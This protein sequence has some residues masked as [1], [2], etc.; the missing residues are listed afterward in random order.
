MPILN[1]TAD[2]GRRADPAQAPRI[3][4]ESEFKIA[5]DTGRS[6]LDLRNRRR[7]SRAPAGGEFGLAER[8]ELRHAETQSHL[9]IMVVLSVPASVVLAWAAFLAAMFSGRATPD[10]KDFSIAMIGAIA[11]LSGA[12]LGYYYGQERTGQDR[13]TPSSSRRK[14]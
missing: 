1:S 7:D 6:D 5:P 3:D 11:G 9:A 12:I 10:I 4:S 8:R 2:G 13:G 14:P